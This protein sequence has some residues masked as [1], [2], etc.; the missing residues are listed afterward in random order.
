MTEPSAEKHRF[1]VPEED[2]SQRLDRFLAARLPEMSRSRLQSL[3]AEGRVRVNGAPAT[4]ASRKVA[5][6][7]VVELELPPPKALELEP[8]DIPLDI[9]FEDDHLIVLNK[10]AGLVVHPA[11]GHEG[12]TLVNA[13]LHHV[14]KTGGRLSG[15][16]GIERPGIV[17]RLDKDTSGLLVIAKSERAH[18]A[19]SEQFAA[20]GRDGRLHRAYLALAWGAP[21]LPT[22]T[23]NAPIAR[24]PKDRTRMAVRHHDESA[25]AAITHYQVQ[26]TFPPGAER[27]A[28]SLLRCT[29]ETGRT[30]Q[31]RVHLAHIGHPVMGDP[32]Y[33]RTHAASANRLPPQARAALAA[34]D[35]QALHAAELGFTHPVT[36]EQM[37]FTA[38]PPADFR[39][40]LKALR[41]WQP[42]PEE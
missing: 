33:A 13:L 28:A 12:G 7:E 10:P 26:E 39:R 23:I 29:L 4:R 41:A 14:Q 18:K 20:H 32:L 21:R 38:P 34:L 11:A 17:H 40:L 31:I 25:R 42:G 16:G 1:T 5:A 37:H 36:G 8:E 30:H 2:A 3:I 24:H 22:G 15:I 6:G 27:P 35:R 9:L 19:L